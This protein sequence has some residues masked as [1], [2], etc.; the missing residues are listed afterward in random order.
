[1]FQQQVLS[2][3]PPLVRSTT[4]ASG[5]S[6]TVVNGDNTYVIQQSVGQ[7][8]AIGT[9]NNKYTVRQGFIQ[10]DVMA[11]VKDVNVPV[12]LQISLYPN[13]FDEQISLV[14]NEEIKGEIKITV[15]N[16]LGAQMFAKGYEAN[17]QI[18]VL[19]GWLSSG[20]YILKANANQKQF[21]SK[22]LKK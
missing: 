3:S 22:I 15:Y 12:N 1:M 20:E 14:F 7:P 9:Y 19:L 2:Q 13:P 8:S 21:I 10:P 17:Q 5:S 11:I 16:M 18:D 4:S 6:D